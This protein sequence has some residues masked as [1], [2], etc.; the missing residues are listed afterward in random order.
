MGMPRSFI[1]AEDLQRGIGLGGAMVE[2]A[3]V[4]L[5]G[6][7]GGGDGVERGRHDFGQQGRRGRGRR[8]A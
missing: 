3:G 6:H 4:D 1:Q 5:D 7:A 8:S 2:A